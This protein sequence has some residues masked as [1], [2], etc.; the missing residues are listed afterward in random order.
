MGLEFAVI[1]KMKLFLVKKDKCLKV[2]Q[3]IFLFIFIYFFY[4]GQSK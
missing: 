4:G 1:K 3:K 2:L